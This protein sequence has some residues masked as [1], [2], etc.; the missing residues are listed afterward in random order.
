MKP[1]RRQANRRRD[2]ESSITVKISERPKNGR[3]ADAVPLVRAQAAV[4][5]YDKDR[6]VIRRIVKYHEIRPSIAVHVTRFQV[7]ADPQIFQNTRSSLCPYSLEGSV[8][9]AQSRRNQVRAEGLLLQYHSN[10]E[11]TVL[12]KV[13]HLK[14]EGRRGT[15]DRGS[16]RK[17][18]VPRKHT[19]T[20][21]ESSYN[22]NV[23]VASYI[24]QSQAVRQVTG[25][26]D[27]GHSN[28]V[29]VS[30]IPENKDVSVDSGTGFFFGQHNVEVAIAIEVGSIDAPVAAG[31]N[32][33]HNGRGECSVT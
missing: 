22:V 29:L 3:V 11:H 13:G 23:A 16:K 27:I 25:K 14:F 30:V 21:R 17:V 1:A 15:H 20:S 2:I 28:E 19:Y 8:T 26:D 31:E 4:R 12:V 32:V 6:H 18:S 7:V 5:V 9:I 24:R 33:C 10:I